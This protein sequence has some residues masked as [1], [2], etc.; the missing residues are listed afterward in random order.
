[1]T[2]SG[3]G[4][5]APLPRFDAY[6]AS[7]AA[8]VRLSENVARAGARVNCVAPGFIAT[9]MHEGTFAAGPQAAGEEYFER[10]REEVERGGADLAKV[11]GLVAFL[12]SDESRDIRGKLIAAQWDPWDEPDFRRRLAD[13]DDLATLRRINDFAFGPIQRGD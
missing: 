2:F 1:V 5:T 4:G 12:L 6:A 7:K 8:V 10:T 11:C 9:D 3:G 13:E